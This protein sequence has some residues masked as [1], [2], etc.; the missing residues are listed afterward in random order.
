MA[1]T[2][3]QVAELY[4]ATF[5]RAPDATGLDYWVN[6]SFDGDPTIEQIAMSFFDQPETQ[7]L[8]PTGSTDTEFVTSIYYNLFKA[9]WIGENGLGGTMTRSIMIEAMKN[10]ATGDDAE[11]IANKAEVGLYYASLGLTGTD[12]SLEDV[13]H[14]NVSVV[15]A[16]AAVDAEADGSY[17]EGI[18]IA[19]ESAAGAD[20]M[21]LTGDQAVR[22]DL[23]ANDDQVTGIDLNSD[24]VIANDSVENNDPTAQDDGVDFEIVDAY[25]RNPLNQTDS[26]NNFLGNIDFDGTGFDGDESD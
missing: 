5:N 11:I 23:T 12:F 20:V 26:Q 17:V 25:A 13:D 15:N 18:D 2:E 14:T 3:Q 8:Y 24:G 4:V 19:V 1:V 7:A 16:M 10:G 22:I 21:R 6:D 9:Y